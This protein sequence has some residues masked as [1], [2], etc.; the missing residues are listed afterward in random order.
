MSPHKQNRSIVICCQV[1]RNLKDFKVETN[2]KGFY[3][4][5]FDYFVLNE[6]YEVQN[7]V[8]H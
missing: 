8:L 7:P 6:I 1:L 2:T 4:I 5:I 3:I